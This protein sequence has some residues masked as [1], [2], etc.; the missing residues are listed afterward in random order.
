MSIQPRDIDED[1]E[2]PPDRLFDLQMDR[3]RDIIVGPKGDLDLTTEETTVEQMVAIR[4]GHVVRQF[5][6]STQDGTEKEKAREKIERILISDP[7]IENVTKVEITDVSS[8]D[9][10]ISIEIFVDENDSFTVDVS[11]D[12]AA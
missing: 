4:T 9:N 12:N 1:V 7:R 11:A 3:F 10:A 2:E 6:G 5:L 8:D